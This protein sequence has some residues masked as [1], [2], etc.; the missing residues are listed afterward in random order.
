MP[1]RLQTKANGGAD[2]VPSL[3]AYLTIGDPDLATSRLIA[4]AA[5]DAGAEV[6]ELGVPFSDPLADGPVIQRAT[7]RALLNKVTL[8]DVLELARFLRTE[9]PQAGLVIFSYLNPVLQYG[10]ERFC[11]DAK[12]AG[13][14]G[15]L[16]T[17]M[18][19]EEADDYLR[20]TQQYGLASIFLVAP[21]SPDARLE[22]I[23]KASQS[24]VY[25]VS[26]L[27]VTG[28]RETLEST[29]EHLVTRLRRYTELPLAVGFGISSG[30]HVEQVGQ[31]A[32][33][34][35]VGSALVAVIEA[36]SRE[37]APAAVARFIG[38]LRPAVA[39]ARS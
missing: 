30:S 2:H 37:L 11:V 25:C 10:M 15:V 20:L 27:G 32:D 38:G 24:F 29:A 23:A 26:R 21:T 14:D 16:L 34:A 22:R 18:T 35:V 12:A 13:V 4:L 6:L 8:A 5:I 31:Y 1:I 3:V 17:D 19:I 9:R 33:A 28:A 39:L 36:S 7:E